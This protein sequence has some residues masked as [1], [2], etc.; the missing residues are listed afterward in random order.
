M[1]WSPVCEQR[2]TWSCRHCPLG[3]QP[4]PSHVLLGLWFGLRFFP[5]FLPSFYSL[6]NEIWLRSQIYPRLSTNLTRLED[7]FGDM[8]THIHV[9][10]FCHAHRCW[11]LG[12]LKSLVSQQRL[13]QN[14]LKPSNL[15]QNS[16]FRVRTYLIVPAVLLWFSAWTLL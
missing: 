14:E 3:P 10:T 8:P 7:L 6:C 2:N 4:P 9:C 15:L 12:Q 13:T 5:S 16:D 11:I 1:W